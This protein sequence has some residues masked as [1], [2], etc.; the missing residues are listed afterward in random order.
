MSIKNI[1]DNDSLL[2]DLKNPIRIEVIPE[3]QRKIAKNEFLIKCRKVSLIDDKFH[4]QKPI[5]MPFLIKIIEKI[6]KKW[7]NFYS[8]FIW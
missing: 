8:K 4:S 6:Q 5:S 2:L 1:I 3:D 7:F